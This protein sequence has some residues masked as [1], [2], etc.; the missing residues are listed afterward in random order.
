M[1]FTAGGYAMNLDIDDLFWKEVAILWVLT[2]IVLEKL[3][4]NC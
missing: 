4:S 2:G 1:S 3:N